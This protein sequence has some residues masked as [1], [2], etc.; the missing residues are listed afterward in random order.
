M[1]SKIERHNILLSC[2]GDVVRLVPTVF[3]A[4][5]DFN[6]HYSDSHKI[7]LHGRHW[8]RDMYPKSGGKPQD[9]INEVVV[10]NC[11]AAIAIF[12][13]KLGSPTDKYESGTV[14]EIEQMLDMGRQVF[15]YFS[16]ESLPY[17]IF[18]EGID[19][20]I[21]DFKKRYKDR[22]VYWE[23]RTEEE[24]SELLSTH[25]RL[26]FVDHAS[27][28]HGTSDASFTRAPLPRL[29]G[30]VDGHVSSVA[31]LQDTFSSPRQQNEDAI[32]EEIHRL[33]ASTV[34]RYAD[35]LDRR[36]RSEA[37]KAR[38]STNDV[39]AV[40]VA[41]ALANLNSASFSIRPGS[42]VTIDEST[43]RIIQ[44]VAEKDGVDLPEGFLTFEELSCFT[45][46][47][48]GGTQYYG[49]EEEE[50]R[51][52]DIMAIDEKISGFCLWKSAREAYS[53]LSNVVLAL[54]NAGTAPDEDVDV[55]LKL[56]T[57][58]LILPQDIP[59]QD[60]HWLSALESEVGLSEY[61]T[62]KTGIRL[63]E[64]PE[65]DPRQPQPM[66]IRYDYDSYALEEFFKCFP[67]EFEEDGKM[68]TVGLNFS[69]IKQHT[70]IAF[71]TPLFLR[72]PI[73]S[74]P[75]EIVSRGVGDVVQGVL[76]VTH[77]DH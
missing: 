44:G 76:D 28:R 2:P 54:E 21:A 29:V 63:R 60:A 37:L 5:D 20:G 69:Q 14:E 66:G 32:R 62:P 45:M 17:E 35:H 22:G 67:Y 41:G 49:P 55:Y 13:C 18:A 58:A 10:P 46:P 6:E 9:L 72:R 11:D 53:G 24:L 34:K 56:P 75:Y 4:L 27:K 74:I 31:L 15:L 57:N 43:K 77:E 3:G 51:Y 61:F 71:P 50:R 7:E 65:A 36:C 47:L 38:M 42:S 26:H 48:D 8:S 59:R 52:L 39:G 12:W 70:A 64:Y 33:L 1:P 25:L 40:S 73:S 68:T 19:P 30:V 23:F 16:K